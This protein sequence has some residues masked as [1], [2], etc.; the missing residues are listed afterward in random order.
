MV[1]IFALGGTPKPTLMTSLGVFI[2]DFFRGFIMRMGCVFSVR[3]LCGG[4]LR[5]VFE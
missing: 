3:R 2:R 5:F 4:S 1:M